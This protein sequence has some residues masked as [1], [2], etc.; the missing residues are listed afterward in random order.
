[1]PTIQEEIAGSLKKISE[2]KQPI[3]WGIIFISGFKPVKVIEGNIFVT[4][5]LSFIEIL[6]DMGIKGKRRS[7]D[8]QRQ[9]EINHRAGY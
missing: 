8:K 5:E 9:I 1:M 6:K 7:I 4:D 3:S 2:I